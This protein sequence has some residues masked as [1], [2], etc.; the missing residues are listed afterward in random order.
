MRSSWTLISVCVAWI[1]GS[2][3]WGKNIFNIVEVFWWPGDNLIKTLVR[4]FSWW[5]WSGDLLTGQWWGGFHGAGVLVLDAERS[6]Q[7]YV[8]GSAALYRLKHGLFFP[9][10]ASL[11]I[12]GN[13]PCSQIFIWCILYIWTKITVY[14]DFK[15]TP[16]GNTLSTLP[17]LCT[18]PDF[19]FSNLSHLPFIHLF[20]CLL[21][22]SVARM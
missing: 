5:G 21:S 4:S 18:L 1:A 17:H 2:A 3:Q 22:V 11:R 6:P 20:I 7:K 16:L 14:L 8:L 12:E 15:L 9:S 13:D 10:A 19:P